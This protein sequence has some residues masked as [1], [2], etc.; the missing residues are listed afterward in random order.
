M[1]LC[2]AAQA[3]TSR[4]LVT[5]SPTPAAASQRRECA[6]KAPPPF[7]PYLDPHAPTLHVLLS[8]RSA[9]AH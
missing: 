6:S 7:P 2:C 9:H 1:P 5:G 4:A 3:S 8:F